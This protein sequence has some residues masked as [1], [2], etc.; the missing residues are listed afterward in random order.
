MWVSGPIYIY[1]AFNSRDGPA[2]MRI[3]ENT[4]RRKSMM[5]CLRLMDVPRVQSEI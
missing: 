3:N 1:Y 4:I 5:E 2:R